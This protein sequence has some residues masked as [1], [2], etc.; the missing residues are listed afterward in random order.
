MGSLLSSLFSLLS[1]LF[2]LLLLLYKNNINIIS[3]ACCCCSRTRHGRLLDVVDSLSY[4]ICQQ[5]ALMFFPG[6]WRCCFRCGGGCC[7]YCIGRFTVH[8]DIK[9]ALRRGGGFEN[10]KIHRLVITKERN[11]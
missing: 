8:I 10:D 5:R 2:S 3:H 7:C 1:S 4:Q 11:R 6:S 9:V